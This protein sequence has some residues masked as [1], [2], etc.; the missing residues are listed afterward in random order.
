MREGCRRSLPTSY[1]ATLEVS[2]VAAALFKEAERVMDFRLL[3]LTAMLFAS[4]RLSKV[5]LWKARK[6]GARQLQHLGVNFRSSSALQQGF[7]GKE[8]M[9]SS[10][11]RSPAL[12]MSQN[13]SGTVPNIFVCRHFILEGK[14]VLLLDMGHGA[15]S[16]LKNKE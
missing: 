7:Q 15:P 3:L 2:W 5:S 6:A 10:L 1:K 11:S 9:G 16:S 14:M 12:G 8:I 4:V 13:G